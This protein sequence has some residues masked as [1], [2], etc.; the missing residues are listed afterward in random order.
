ME[1]SLPPGGAA[2]RRAGA[3]RDANDVGRIPVRRVP[4]NS[5][6]TIPQRGL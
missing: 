5:K 1:R 4:A 3:I 6:V 2:Q